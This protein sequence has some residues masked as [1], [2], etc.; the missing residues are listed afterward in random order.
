MSCTAHKKRV[1]WMQERIKI[2]LCSLTS[3][4][5][6]GWNQ[7]WIEMAMSLH[8][9]KTILSSRHTMLFFLWKEYN[10]KLNWILEYWNHRWLY[11]KLGEILL[12]KNPL[13]SQSL[14]F[15]FVLSWHLG[16]CLSS[17]TSRSHFFAQLFFSRGTFW[18]RNPDKIACIK[19]TA[20]GLHGSV[21]PFQAIRS[22]RESDEQLLIAFLYHLLKCRIKIQK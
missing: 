3:L 14:G 20:I 13:S 12:S 21:L 11:K 2:C 18:W 19:G 4:K 7:I 16:A 15:I 6:R 1:E 17:Q 5:R 9:V 10:F 22:K 8:E